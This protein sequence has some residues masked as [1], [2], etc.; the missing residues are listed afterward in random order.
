[1]SLIFKINLFFSITNSDLNNFADD[2]TISSVSNISN[3][4][5][6]ETSGTPDTKTSKAL[7]VLFF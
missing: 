1:M 5:N 4:S 6:I 7:Q 2:K 3:V